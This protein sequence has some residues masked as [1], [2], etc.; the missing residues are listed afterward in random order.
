MVLPSVESSKSAFVFSLSFLYL[1]HFVQKEG[2]EDNQSVRRQAVPF[3]STI[4]LNAVVASDLSDCSSICS[5]RLTSQAAGAFR[6]YAVA[7]Q[8]HRAKQEVLVAARFLKAAA[9][10]SVSFIPAAS[11]AWGGDSL[12]TLVVVA[13]PR[14]R[15]C[16]LARHRHLSCLSLEADF[17]WSC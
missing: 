4:S 3:I 10:N 5:D 6:G 14:L 17:L 16:S 9:Q 8:D 11:R 15:P 7:T 1:T 13:L 2:R 12:A